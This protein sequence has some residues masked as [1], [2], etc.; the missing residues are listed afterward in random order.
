MSVPSNKIPCHRCHN[1]PAVYEEI[2]V[3]CTLT[4]L[5]EYQDIGSGKL[6][7]WSPKK[8][9]HVRQTPLLGK[10]V[11]VA[12]DHD[13]RTMRSLCEDCIDESFKGKI[14]K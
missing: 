4:L 1:K 6:P 13:G 8:Q 7:K 12:R 10:S 14:K 9:R 3:P 11:K 5:Y 2:Y